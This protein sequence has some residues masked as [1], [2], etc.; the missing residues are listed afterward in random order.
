[1]E[2]IKLKQEKYK[3]WK[4]F[5]MARKKI[6][7]TDSSPIVQDLVLL[8]FKQSKK[9]L[10]EKLKECIENDKY[11]IFFQSDF[12][13][14]VKNIFSIND[15]EEIFFRGIEIYEKDVMKNGGRKD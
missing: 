14:I 13:Q 15:N 9:I 3:K 8:D 4:L 11:F 2:D 6:L 1:M 10:K 5:K 12:P 7:L